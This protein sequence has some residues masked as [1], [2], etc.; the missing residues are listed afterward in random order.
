MMK[1][2]SLLH[3]PSRTRRMD[4]EKADY[5]ERIRPIKVAQGMIAG[6]D[7]T[8]DERSGPNPTSYDIPLFELPL[9]HSLGDAIDVKSIPTMTMRA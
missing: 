9:G 1:G 6:S 3:Q 5:G 2:V 4:E 8:E 7:L